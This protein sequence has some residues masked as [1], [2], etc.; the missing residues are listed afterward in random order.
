[1]VNDKHLFYFIYILQV[2]VISN[3]KDNIY[4]GGKYEYTSN[5]FNIYEKIIEL[6]FYFKL[7]LFFIK[8]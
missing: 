4:L 8:N 3:I 1:M 6:Y 2:K 5:F 7:L